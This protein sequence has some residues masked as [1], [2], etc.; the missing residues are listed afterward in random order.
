VKL[1]RLVSA[2]IVLIIITV[3][4][5]PMRGVV[6]F[7]PK[8]NI[9]V[10][11]SSGFWWK[12]Q[13]D[14]LRIDDLNLGAI[15][16]DLN[17]LGLLSGKIKFKVRQKNILL[18]SSGYLS[19]SFSYWELEDIKFK[20]DFTESTLRS[21]IYSSEGYIEKLIFNNKGCIEAQGNINAKVSDIFGLFSRELLLSSNL[22]CK[23]D[24]LYGTFQAKDK[25]VLNGYFSLN[26][27]S[28]YKMEAYS[29]KLDSKLNELRKLKINLEPSIKSEGSL[30]DLITSLS[31]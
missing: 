25:S 30:S 8:D 28:Y 6:L 14:S 12:G 4:T 10:L 11:G 5:F 26:V 24:S 19:R 9:A 3:V 2:L 22:T 27:D 18:S 29:Q 16:L 20:L 31:Q 21:S 1:K 15:S 13:I 17:L 23:D 7:I